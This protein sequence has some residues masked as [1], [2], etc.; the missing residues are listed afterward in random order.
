MGQ[1]FFYTSGG[2]EVGPVTAAELK[3]AASSGKLKPN[4]KI[5]KDGSDNW[6]TASQIKGLFPDGQARVQQ[7]AGDVE[8]AAKTVGKVAKATGKVADAVKDVAGAGDKVGQAATAVAGLTAGGSTLLGGVGDFLRPVGPVNLV[9]FGVATVSAV[10]FF[11]VARRRGAKIKL[12]VNIGTV[13]SLAV[14]LVFGGW[15][16]LG[17]ATGQ[18]NKGA[19]ATNIPAVERAQEAVLP[20]TATAPAEPAPQ[21]ADDRVPKAGAEVASPPAV[22]PA[23]EPAD[24]V[25]GKRLSGL[26]DW[27]GASKDW[28]PVAGGFV[29]RGGSNIV[30]GQPLPA[31]CTIE[32]DIKVIAGKRPRL[33]LF[34]D[35]GSES[36]NV[37]IEPRGGENVLSVFMKPVGL[38]NLSAVPI[39]WRTN[40]PTPV[41]LVFT[42]DQ[43]EFWF[44]GKLSVRARRPQAGPVRLGASC[45]D[46]SIPGIVEFTNFRFTKPR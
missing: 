17:A 12:K 37:V 34:A 30:F 5:H 40:E 11:L 24:V 26:A 45:G 36:F 25:N 32:F 41:R 33:F 28:E 21:P 13:V 6:T 43:F 10:V 35:K 16:G 9:V 14:A 2:E 46:G 4:G 31:H 7:K 27:P 18:G 1:Q 44:D 3:A 22:R 42:G 8:K 19:L 39:P 38:E 20:L 15:A 23:P 29:G